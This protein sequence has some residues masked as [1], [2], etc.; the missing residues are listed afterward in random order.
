MLHSATNLIKD[1]HLKDFFGGVKGSNLSKALSLLFLNNWG[2]GVRACCIM[3]YKNHSRSADLPSWRESFEAGNYLTLTLPNRM[4]TS[5]QKSSGPGLVPVWRG[6]P[7]PPISHPSVAWLPTRG[8]SVRV[9][10][11]SE[12][13]ATAT[14]RRQALNL[15]IS[16]WKLKLRERRGETAAYSFG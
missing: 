9:V 14:K 7:P 8:G 4:E 12:R 15:P 3:F 10:D 11:R 1:N 2:G 6:F 5:V 16:E 13:P